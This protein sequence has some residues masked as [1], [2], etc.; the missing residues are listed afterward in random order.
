MVRLQIDFNV[1]DV[2]VFLL[3][4]IMFWS[5]VWSLI[6]ERLKVGGQLLFFVSSWVILFK[7]CGLNFNARLKS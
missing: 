3:S 6:R 4:Y 2:V 5:K 1:I 7:M